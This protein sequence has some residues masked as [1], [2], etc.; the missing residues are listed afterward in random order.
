M[1]RGTSLSTLALVLLATVGCSDT[2][3]TQ[4]LASPRD[5]S[6]AKQST[7]NSR[8]LYYDFGND[9]IMNDDGTAATALTISADGAYDPSWAPDGKRILFNAYRGEPEASIYVMNDDGSAVTRITHP[10]ALNIDLRPT[11]FGKG[12]AFVRWNLSAGSE[13]IY[14]VNLDGSGETWIAAGRNPAAAPSG[15]K[16]AYVSG[17][18]IWEYDAAT[19]VSTNLTNTPSTIESDPSYS[20]NGKQIVF[21]AMSQAG[22]GIYVMRPDGSAITRV[23]WSDVGSHGLPKWS[24]D[25]K[26]LAFTRSETTVAA[27]DIYVMNVDG[28]GVTNLTNS[29]ATYEML[30]AWAR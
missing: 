14:R 26:R 22:S 19:G 12:V 21:A 5:A 16:L 28:S 27:T 4:P 18:D 15:D 23:T 24:P 8:M 25:G 1:N 13:D 17:D 10:S 3:P 2:T 30:T 29:P 7:T 11:R 20:P 9:Y 6:F